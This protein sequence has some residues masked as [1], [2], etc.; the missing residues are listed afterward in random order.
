[1]PRVVLQAFTMSILYTN[2]T[3]TNRGMILR[4]L[5]ENVNDLLQSATHSVFTPQDKLAR[6]HALIVY[7]CIKLFD[8]DIS[9]G[10]Q[11]EKDMSL[12]DS[13]LGELCKVRDNLAAEA[14]MDNT[15]LRDRPPESWEAS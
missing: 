4:V 1:M 2:K 12:L 5:H 14:K 15:T 3:E 7:Q 13:W 6:V 11:A 10:G 9:L 8:G